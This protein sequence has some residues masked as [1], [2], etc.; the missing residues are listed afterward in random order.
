[1]NANDWARIEFTVKKPGKFQLEGLIG[2]GNGSGGS[3]VRFEIAPSGSTAEPQ[4]LSYTVKET[5]GFQSFV[6]TPLG[7]VTLDQPG[8][9][10]LR[11]KAVKKPGVAV[12]DLRQARLIPQK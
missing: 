7:E 3:E 1:V 4:T 11:I 8:R 10:E 6:P 5:G 2:C 12:M 9:F